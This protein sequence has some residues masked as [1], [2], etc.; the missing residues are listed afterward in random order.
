MTT[1]SWISSWLQSHH[2]YNLIMTTFSSPSNDP[3]FAPD[4]PVYYPARWLMTLR[5]SDIH[6]WSPLAY[7][8]S[9]VTFSHLHIS[10]SWQWTHSGSTNVCPEN[11][12]TRLHMSLGTMTAYLPKT[13][14]QHHL[15]QVTH[16]VMPPPEQA[17][18]PPIGYPGQ[19]GTRSWD[20]K[21]QFWLSHSHHWARALT[22]SLLLLVLAH[23]FIEN[24]PF[25]QRLE[26]PISTPPLLENDPTPFTKNRRLVPGFSCS[27]G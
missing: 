4:L 21:T 26:L 8:E 23:Q 7:I 10:N 20:Q 16:A 27:T 19:L 5:L 25:W 11:F 14:P 2:D 22:L 24:P 18:W 13:C 3:L 12:T 15:R 9:L 17:F 6:P 1:F